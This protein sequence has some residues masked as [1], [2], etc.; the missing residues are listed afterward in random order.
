MRDDALVNGA[1]IESG[2]KFIQKSVSA[3]KREK[4]FLDNRVQVWYP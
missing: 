1:A 2:G 4:G 3:A